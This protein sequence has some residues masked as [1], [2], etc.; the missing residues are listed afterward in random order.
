MINLKFLQSTAAKIR[1]ANLLYRITKFLRIPII[2]TI[3]R[4]QITYEVDLREGIDLSLYWLGSFQ[5]HIVKCLRPYI[6][7]APNNCSVLD[8][9]ANFGLVGLSLARYLPAANIYM[10]EP[11]DYAFEKL[12]KNVLLNKDLQTR[13]FPIQTFVGEHSSDNSAFTAFASWRVDHVHSKNSDQHPIHLGIKKAAPAYQISLDDFVQQNNINSVFLIKIDTEGYEFNVIKGAS[14]TLAAYKP[15]VIFE[16]SL[17]QMIEHNLTLADFEAF[18]LP[19]GYKLFNSETLKSLTSNSLT[20]I[21][22]G[23]GID[24]LA[25]PPHLL[26]D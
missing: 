24:V 20:Q 15:I 23:G 26:A 12:K 18:F 2:Q 13:L 5:S 21:P 14:K 11:T 10:F 19:L 17:Y 3:Q 16:L 6:N 25:L 9:G 1:V 4:N 8:V 22:K 7:N